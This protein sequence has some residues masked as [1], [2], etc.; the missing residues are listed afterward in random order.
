MYCPKCG[1]KIPDD[2]FICNS[3]K[4]HSKNNKV[5]EVKEQKTD[6]EEKKA[7]NVFKKQLL[8]YITKDIYIKRI[9]DEI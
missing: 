8:K 2:G 6:E 5:D 9:D 3:S 4:S 1:S 7:N